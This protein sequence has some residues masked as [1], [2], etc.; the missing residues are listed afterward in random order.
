MRVSNDRGVSHWNKPAGRQIA[1]F[2]STHPARGR[3]RSLVIVGEKVKDAV[4]KQQRQFGLD[5]MAKAGG[6]PAGRG[7]RNHDIPQRRASPPALAPVAEAKRQNIRR[8]IHTPVSVIE[9]MDRRVV[10]KP[11]PHLGIHQPLA[12]EHLRHQTTCQALEASPPDGSRTRGFPYLNDVTHTGVVSL[13]G[14]LSFLKSPT[15]SAIP[16]RA[17][18]QVY[19]PQTPARKSVC[20]ANPGRIFS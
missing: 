6:L 1:A 14:S 8:T 7:H 3:R 5:R 2:C 19:K 17:V 16:G 18:Q 10:Y 11:N 13:S 12:V 4:N 9:A 20:P 15:R